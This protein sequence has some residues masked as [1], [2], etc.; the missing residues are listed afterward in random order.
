MDVDEVGL[1][2]AVFAAVGVG[3]GVAGVAATGWAEAAF[4]TEAGG[5]AGR[6]GPVFV[7]QLYLSVTA[8]AL[9]GAPVLAGA[10][11]L[12][13]GSRS[14]RVGAAA[15]TCGLGSGAGALLYGLVVVTLVVATQG[16]AATQAYGFTDALGPVVG[17][18]VGS[19]LV[20]S[21]AGALGSWA[22]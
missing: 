13:V 20:G 12:L 8:A 3:V 1:V 16:D 19:A 6:F 15:A 17:V 11:G 4:A 21:I 22:G 18:A 5:D 14:Y 7:A 10:I 2:V 9:V